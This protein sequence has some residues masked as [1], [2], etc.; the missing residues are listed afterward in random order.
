MK[1]DSQNESKVAFAFSKQAAYFDDLY[2]GNLII[3]YKRNRVRTQLLKYLK[4]K[5][6]ILELNAGTGEDAVF[7]ARLGHKV[8]ATDSASGMMRELRLKIVATGLENQVSTELCSFTALETLAERRSYDC[9]FS[10]FAGLNCTDRLEK[11]LKSLDGLV[12]PGGIVVLV[13]LP[14]FCLWEAMLLFKGKAKTATRRFFSGKGRSA[15]IENDG[16]SCW[17]YNPGFIKKTMREKFDVLE[18]E[19]LCT[20][21]P[22]SYMNGFPLKYPKIY[23]W[24][25]KAEDAWKKSW[26]WKYIGDYYV[27]TLKKR[28]VI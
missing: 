4:P 14:K 6:Q 15:K 26:P 18:I 21:V 12:K 19:G 5:S 17:Y 27:I 7:L 11:V 24:L 22:P 3:Q 1:L 23:G 8:H 20:L 13:I 28:D 9:I 16:F 25:C 10:N 2:S